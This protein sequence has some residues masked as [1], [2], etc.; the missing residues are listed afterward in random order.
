MA[1]SEP[2]AVIDATWAIVV[3]EANEGMFRALG[4]CRTSGLKLTERTANNLFETFTAGLTQSV[5]ALFRRSGL[6]ATTPASELGQV[7]A[8]TVH[9]IGQHLD[10]GAR[11]GD[12]EGTYA[13]VWLGLL[14]L[15]RPAGAGTR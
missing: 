3:T 2:D 15:T 4:S 9:G 13:A 11:A 7:L 1:A 10:A 8:A 14:A 12:W 5:E 6:Q